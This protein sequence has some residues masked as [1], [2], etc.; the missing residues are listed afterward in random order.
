MADLNKFGVAVIGPHANAALLADTMNQFQSRY[1]LE[2][3][4]ER[5]AFSPIPLR[6]VS[7]RLCE[8]SRWLFS[9]SREEGIRVSTFDS[10]P[11]SRY[12]GVEEAEYL[13]LGALLAMA[14]WRVLHVNPLINPEDWIHEPDTGCLFSAQESV[15]EFALVTEHGLVCPS[16]SGF[17]CCLGAE[18]ELALILGLAER[19]R[20]V[21]A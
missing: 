6:P 12:L 15:Q 11:I 13:M 21:T 5:A 10:V 17:Y 16:C 14:Q 8:E 2:W 9:V 19:F 4:H 20:L 1:A 7:V 18:T 3:V